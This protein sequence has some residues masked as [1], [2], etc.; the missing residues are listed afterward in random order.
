MMISFP[1]DIYPVVKLYYIIVV[2]LVFLRSLHTIFSDSLFSFSKMTIL[3]KITGYLI[4]Y[5]F[6]WFG[7]FETGVFSTLS[8]NF[9][10]I[11][12]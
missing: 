12:D 4:V 3:I 2:F 11:L 5:L 9:L 6:G 7:F 8:C 10:C 1:L